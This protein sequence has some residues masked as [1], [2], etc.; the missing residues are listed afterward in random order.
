MHILRTIAL[1]VLTVPFAAA[2]HATGVGAC[3]WSQLPA[4][5]HRAVFQGYHAGM[6][7]GMS[8]LAK[9]DAQVR[10]GVAVCVRQVAVPKNW[11]QAVVASEVIQ[12]GA[13]MESASVGGPNRRQLDAAWRE[14]PAP[15]RECFRANASRVFGIQGGSCPDPKAPGWFLQRF[16]IS[17]TSQRALAS[18]VLIFSNA[19]AQSEWAEALI[20][21]FAEQNAKP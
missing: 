2:A 14:A 20:S 13:A 3:A 15:S 7:S 17:P 8:E 6:R 4:E 21:R 9:R 16:N 18:Q 1:A 19:K 10:A 12:E 11:A 5:D